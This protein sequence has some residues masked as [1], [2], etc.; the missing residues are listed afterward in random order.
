MTLADPVAQYVPAFGD[1]KVGVENGDRLDLEAAKRPMTVQ[2]LLRHTSG[3]TYGFTGATKV[4]SLLLASDTYNLDKT[5]AEQ[6]DALA[7]LPLQHQPGECWEYGHSTDVLG[8]VV[9]VVAG[10]RLSDV[11]RERIFQPLGMEDTAFFT[12]AQ[13]L[14][15]RAEPDSINFLKTWSINPMDVTTPPLYEMGGTGL[16]STLGDYARF[17]AMLSGGGVLD[18]IR[19]LGP[20]TVTYM[21]SDHLG[22]AVPRRSAWLAPGYGFGL[23]FS[24]RTEA[25]VVPVTGSVGDYFWGGVA[26]TLFWVS[27]RD[28]LFA[29]F[30]VQAPDY[31]VYLRTLFRNLVNAAIV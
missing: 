3:L 2:D 29:V 31:F 21:A 30:M 11:L 24:V 27:P 17:A 8:R 15:R 13:K 26:G 22:S 4:Q 19:V 10:G 14:A 9:E 23:G 25:G 7:R 28:N 16:M 5:T 12:P 1:V 20:R 6:V 18:G